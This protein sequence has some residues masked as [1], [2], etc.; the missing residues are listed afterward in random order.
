MRDVCSDAEMIALIRAA[1]QGDPV[2]FDQIYNYYSDKLF[3]F[4]YVRLGER[5]TAEDLMAEAFVRLV[6]TLPRYRVDSTRPVAAFSAWLYRIASNLLTDH[7]R[8]Q[9]SRAHADFSD[10][11]WLLAADP[12]PYERME[13]NEIAEDVWGAVHQLSSEQQAVVL[14]RFSEQLSLVEVAE[15][16]GKSA[17]AVKALQHR[18]LTNLRRLLTSA[19]PA[20]GKEP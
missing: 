11:S 5:E 14:F 13:R 1:Q 18:A 4:L 8:R 10:Q 3:R 6:E 9:R 19:A 12:L 20:D 16:M 15:M 17:G 7:Y 2:A